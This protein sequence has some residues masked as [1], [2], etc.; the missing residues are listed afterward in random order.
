MHDTCKITYL[1]HKGTINMLI[2]AVVKDSRFD[3]HANIEEDIYFLKSGLSLKAGMICIPVSVNSCKHRLFF[4][5]F[6]LSKL[7]NNE[8]RRN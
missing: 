8:I 4:S 6:S 2:T 5:H 3:D 1:A 7:W